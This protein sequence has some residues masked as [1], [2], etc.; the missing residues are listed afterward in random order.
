L[1]SAIVLAIWA[2]LAVWAVVVTRWRRGLPI[3]PYQPRRP[4][5]WR[6]IDLLF[7]LAFYLVSVI[8]LGSL[9][10]PILGPE[11]V[12]GPAIYD[13][14]KATAA[15]TIANLLAEANVWV[16]LLCVLSAVVVAPIVEEFLF[17][18]LLQG[19]LET[20]Q[21][22][23]RPRMPSLQRWVPGAIGPVAITSCLFALMHFRVQGP[24]RHVSYRVY[25]V[26]GSLIVGLAVTAFAV[27]MLRVRAGATVEDLGV[28]PDKL[29][30]D[31]RLGMLAFAGLAAPMYA[32]ML[33]LGKLLPSYIA[34]DPLVLFFFSVALGTL[35]YRTHRIVPA[36]VLHMSLN[37][38]SLAMALKIMQK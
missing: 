14:E 20:L 27:L 11:I 12:R 26:A 32:A 17:R 34:P 4:V 38:T 36:I 33:L 35:Y 25:E 29:L 23:L 30:A 19:W 1:L 10:R 16:L 2:C 21:R 8:L 13:L 6:G 9:A 7:V 15:H 3:L 28:A 18:V 22:R 24:P 31:V 37:A 5:P